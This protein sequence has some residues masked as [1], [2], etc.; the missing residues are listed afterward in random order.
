MTLPIIRFS[1]IALLLIA[2]GQSTKPADQ[3]D[4]TTRDVSKDPAYQKGLT[5]IKGSDCL[6]CHQVADKAIG[7]SYR[8]IAQKYAG[9]N[10]ETLSAVAQKIIKGG[11]GVWGQVPMTPHPSLSTQDAEAMLQYILL[12]K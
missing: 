7:P 11:S 5:L 6:T 3:T 9:V 8:D 2:C 12:L 10:D 4:G 1:V